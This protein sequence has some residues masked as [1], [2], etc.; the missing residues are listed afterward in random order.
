M[1]TPKRHKY[2]TWKKTLGK[3]KIVNSP[4]DLFE[5][6]EPYIDH[7]EKVIQNLLEKIKLLEEK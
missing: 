3:K 7:L 1:G 2:D 6:N 5:V 4:K